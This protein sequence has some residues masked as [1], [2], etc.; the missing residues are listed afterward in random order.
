MTSRN[1]YDTIGLNGMIFI[2][3]VMMNSEAVNYRRGFPPLPISLGEH[4]QVKF[5]GFCACLLY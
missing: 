2:T 1:R 4:G 3:S 5:C